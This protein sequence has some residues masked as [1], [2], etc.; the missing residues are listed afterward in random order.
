[1]GGV[2]LGWFFWQLRSQSLLPYHD[3]NYVEAS[4]TEHALE[5]S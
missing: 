3:P 2:W 4:S 1:M 5:L